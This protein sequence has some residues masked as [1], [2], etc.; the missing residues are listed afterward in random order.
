MEMFSVS[1]FPSYVFIDRHGKFQPSAIHRPS[2]MT[3]EDLVE[4]LKE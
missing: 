4:L 3:R 1:G 2:H